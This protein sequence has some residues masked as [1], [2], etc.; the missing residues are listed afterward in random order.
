MR[1]SSNMFQNCDIVIVNLFCKITEQDTHPWTK[2][3]NFWD[4]GLIPSIFEQP[5]TSLLDYCYPPTI[6]FR[7]GLL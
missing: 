7:S 3:Y 5:K 2:I 4:F 1:C 6:Y